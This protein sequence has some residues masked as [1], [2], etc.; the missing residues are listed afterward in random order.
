MRLFRTALLVGLLVI[1]G[2]AI[3]QTMLWLGMWE[4][5]NGSQVKDLKGDDQEI[6]LIEPATST[7]EWGRLV[8]A[9]EL[10]QADW[11]RLNPTLPVLQVNLKRAFPPLTAE[12]PEIVL[13]FAS[14]P[15]QK[16]HLRWYKITGEHNVESW[17]AKLHARQRPPLAVIGGGTSDRAVRLARALQQTYPDVDSASPT[18][19][20]TTATAEKTDDEKLLIEQY[21]K[22][23]FRFSFTNK[24]M[25]EAIL[26]FMQQT[27][28]LWVNRPADTQGKHSMYAF[29]WQDE[30]Y[31][32]DLATL[33]IDEFKDRFPEGVFIDEGGIQHAVGDFF[34]P[35]PD[36]Q[37]AVGIFV[38]RHRPIPPRSFL[39]LP[40]QTVRMR[41]FLI[42]LYQRSPPDARN[43]VVVNGD[44][45]SFNSVFRDRDVL[46]N[47]S[48]LPYSLVFF[49]HRNPVDRAAG[50]SEKE[51]SARP[52]DALPQRSST[53]THDILLYRDIFGALLYA[54]HDQGRL[55][56]DPRLVRE[57][58]RSTA[59]YPSTP[60][61]A[62]E[63]PPRVCNTLVHEL[64]PEP[65]RFFA[66]K[67]GDRRRDTGE[68]IVW[69]KPN[70]IDDRPEPSSKITVWSMVP[71]TKGEAWRLVGDPFDVG[72][73]Q[74][75]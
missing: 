10:M 68:H 13:S 66:N 57:R 25:V 18:L 51:E 70:F 26:K 52:A 39:V 62:S 47:V 56:D 5:V 71:N 17:I 46:W 60:E 72:Y 67:R 34:R 9:L 35:A 50:F 55:Q 75:R 15:T 27:P 1:L 49:A 16:L 22:R 64:R 44:A 12:V 11:P 45:I 4:S 48:D 53:G 36:E 2:V 24:R 40:T 38:E 23:V 65:R 7:D 63:D 20:I 58:L 6:A 31:S 8:T 37:R 3:Y 21:E 73:N 14:A 59:W 74:S 28:D 33:F 30:R 43:L 32:K 69:V 61:R 19:L 41:R 42:N 54:V 29:Y